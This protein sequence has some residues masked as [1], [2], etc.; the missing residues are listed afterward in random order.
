MRKETISSFWHSKNKKNTIS[1]L[2]LLSIKSWLDNGYKFRLYTYDLENHFFL[3]IKKI[4]QDDFELKDANE[5]IPSSELFYDDR[6]SGMASFAD[7]FRYK[8]LNEG[9]GYGQIQI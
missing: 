3:N 6:S 5:I 7:L 4:Y 2:E 9:G 1:S 8:M